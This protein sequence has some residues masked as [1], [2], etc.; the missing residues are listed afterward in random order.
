[1]IKKGQETQT[2]LNKLGQPIGFEVV[3]WQGVEAPTKII[4]SG[5]YCRLEPLAPDKHAK[6]L[7]EANCLDQ[8]DRIWTYLPYGPFADFDSYHAWLKN[9]CLGD[10]PLFYT[11]IDNRS[12]KA[13]GV[14]S[15][16]R[17]D[18][19]N[20]SIEV[21]HLCYSPLLTKT[22]AATEAMYLMMK[23]MFDAGYRRYEW[24]C[25]ALNYP[26]RSAAQRLGF[27]FEG[28]FRN[29]IVTKGRNRDTA[30]F[31]II[32]SEWLALQKVFQQWLS[33]DNFDQ[34]GRQKTSLSEMTR[35]LLASIDN[36]E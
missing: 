36:R 2:E 15:Y 9:N 11:L 1:M 22:I 8:K 12:E 35:P 31:S 21:G 18:P 19:A 20:G 17:I 34:D 27:S 26:S 33:P 13:V 10:S 4:L 24:K 23:N 16:L 3:N 6:Q 14:A 30:W 29:S 7:Y 25:N 32:D 5:E 28:I